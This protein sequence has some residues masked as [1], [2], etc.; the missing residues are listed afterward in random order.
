VRILVI[1][2]EVTIA[3]FIQRG[4]MA[5]GYAVDIATDGASGLARARDD[6]V[7]L[8]VLDRML[9][10]LDGLAVL[11]GIRSV[12]PQLP[13]I[14]LT[15]RTGIADRVEGLDAGA[16][17]YLVKPFAF[18]ELAARVRA[19]LRGQQDTPA[20]RLE[21]DGIAVDLL[22]REVS[23]DGLPVRLSTKEF[24]LLAYLMRRPDVVHTRERILQDVWGYDHDPATNVVDVYVSYLRRKLTAA[25]GAPAP[26]ATI[27]SVGY[28]MIADA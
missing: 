26:I 8:V 20:T 13:V 1:E 6:A 3:D 4:L 10:R 12:R 9:P 21:F 16:T 18:D 25:T 19:H 17:D 22:A 28:R 11:R 23:R 24:E 15:A 5:D 14:M 27:R 7:D 2:D